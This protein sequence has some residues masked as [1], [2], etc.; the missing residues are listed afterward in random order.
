MKSG[1]RKIAEN[2]VKTLVDK[3]YTAYFAGGSV[4]DIVM[5]IE[6]KDY[7]IATNATPDEISKIFKRTI[8]VGAKFGVSIVIL[9]GINFE[10]AT[11]RSD[12]DYKDG[13]H[14][15]KVIF[16]NE[17]EDVKRRD[18]T[19][20]GLLYDPLENK[21][22]DYVG[23][24]YD[25]NNKLIRTIGDAHNRFNEDKLRMM[26]AIRLAVRFGF[27]IEQKT[28]EAIVQKAPEI[29]EISKE[30]IRDELIKV[31]TE[32]SAGK[33]IRLLDKTGILQVILPEVIEMKG[34]E[35]PPDFHPEGDV[36]T[37]TVL[38]FD[39]MENPSIELAIGV[40][41]H[42][43]GKPKTFEIRDRIRFN[44]HTEVGI[45]IADDI[46]KRFKFTNK[47]IEHILNLI[48]NHLKFKD[49]Q[50]MKE[51]TLKRFLRMEK[52]DE[53]LELHRL[54][55]LASHGNLEN[56]E[57]CKK[58][59]KEIS[60]EERKPKRFITG[61]D[62][63]NAGFIPGPEFK[64]ILD[65]AEDEQLEGRVKDKNEAMNLIMQKFNNLLVK[66]D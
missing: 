58:M 11:F 41:L 66:N 34:V 42:D 28:F 53:H 46:L 19:I 59:L 26:R 10:V 65:Y 29:L 14:P 4:R 6:P 55:C 35:Q 44:E 33:G 16:T 5:G 24:Q 63:I 62:L 36:F 51:S 31:L 17:K 12:F 7:D 3:G 38:M 52:F 61:D 50:N 13:R 2:I 32:G 22:I 54:D 8:L 60:T 30:R 39:L 18:F 23:G 1:L 27:D 45:K 43:I 49:I 64:E 48:K 20:N 15:E 9:D 40:L 57:Y 56:Y 21:V 25:I 37:H 47:E